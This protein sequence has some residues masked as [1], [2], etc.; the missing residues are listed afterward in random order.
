M[1]KFKM[2]LTWHNCKTC[3]PEEEYNHWLVCSDGKEVFDVSYYKPLGFPID[4]QYLHEYWWADLVQTVKKTKEF[5][6][7]EDEQ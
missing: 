7:E 4:P 1:D 2:E 6:G 5:K 3:P